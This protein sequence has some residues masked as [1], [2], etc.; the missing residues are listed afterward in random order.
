MIEKNERI[1]KQ[2]D[3]T[4]RQCKRNYLQSSELQTQQGKG[5]VYPSFFFKR[6][7]F[8]HNDVPGEKDKTKKMKQNIL[9]DYQT[10]IIP[11]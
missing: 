6:Y 2:M 4:T 5:I 10:D 8:I 11:V 9:L 1:N 3:V 7:W